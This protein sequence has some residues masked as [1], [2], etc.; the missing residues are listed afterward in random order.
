MEIS[1]IMQIVNAVLGILFVFAGAYALKF[2]AK[3]S[4]IRTFFDTLDDAMI[5]DRISENEWNDIY[6]IFK[7]VVS[8]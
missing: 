8:K 7:K 6:K 1:E 3:L 4:S 2:K 5:D